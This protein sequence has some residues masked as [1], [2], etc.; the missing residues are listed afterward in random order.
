MPSTTSKTKP[1]HSWHFA[2]IGTEWLIE[3]DQVIQDSVR[4]TITERIKAY[5]AAYSRFRDDSVVGRIAKAA[6]EYD[7][8]AGTAKLVTFYKQLYGATDG[9]VSPLVG[10]AL[11]AAGYDKEY[12]LQPS[13]VP[14]VPTWEQAMVW[15]DDHVTVPHLVTLDF[16][17]AG[18]G[19]LVD[20]VGAILEGHGYLA[21]T[22]DASGDVRSRGVKEVIGLEDPAD[23]SQVIGAVEI[24]DASLCASATNRREW[25]EGW[26]HVLDART[27]LPVRDVM[28][29][30][31]IADETLMA[32]GLATALFF[33]PASRLAHIGSFEYVRLLADGTVEYSKRFVG[34][35]Y[36]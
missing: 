23:P 22:I 20:I 2:A 16:G 6:G 33:V 15:H 32:D 18:K 7:F 31:V 24:E 12:S 5:D 36:T 14:Q 21:Y 4:R 13:A 34:Q 9:A 17:A 35:L 27:G 26:H 11:A 8:P 10:E 19:Y 1:K 3:T 29:T 28:A 30:W 25:G